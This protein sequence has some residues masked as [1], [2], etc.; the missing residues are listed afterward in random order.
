METT[1]TKLSTIR[2]AAAVAIAAVLLSA[3]TGA[4]AASRGPSGR[5]AATISHP[6]AAPT[7][8]VPTRGSGGLNWG[9]RRYGYGWCYWHPYACSYRR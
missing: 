6:V 7:Q 9:G 2:I 1:V 4:Q 5:G 3:A 8:A